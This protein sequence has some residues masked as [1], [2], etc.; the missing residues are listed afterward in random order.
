M[1]LDKDDVKV[2]VREN[3][4]DDEYVRVETIGN[5]SFGKVVKCIEKASGEKVAVKIID[6]S[7]YSVKY[8]EKLKSEIHILEKLNHPN[9]IEFRRCIETQDYLYFVM[10]F[11]KNGTLANF[12]NQRFSSGKSFYLFIR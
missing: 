7:K 11:I 12:M 10:N 3:L 9:I 5:G 4:F 8:I 2:E 6:I 1:E